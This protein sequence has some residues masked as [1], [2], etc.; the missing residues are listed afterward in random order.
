MKLFHLDTDFLVYAFAVRG[1]ERRR[2]LALSESDAELQISA[3]VWYEYT[4]GPRTVELLSAV[5]SYFSESGIIPMSE[6]IALNAGEL[7]R[8]LG[9]PR[10]RAADIA[11]GATAVISKATLITRNRRD[12]A[13]IADLQIEEVT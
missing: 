2:F 8:R 13:G 11:I 7:F 6:D 10:K 9:S 1:P 4:R 3:L 5:R 12:F